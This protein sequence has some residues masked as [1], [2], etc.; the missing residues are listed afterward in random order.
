[1]ETGSGGGEQND[2]SGGVSQVAHAEGAVNGG[3]GGGW[4]P[5]STNCS[6]TTGFDEWPRAFCRPAQDFDSPPPA[7]SAAGAVERTVTAAV[8]MT[9]SRTCTKNWVLF[10]GTPFGEVR[11]SRGASS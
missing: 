9:A 7:A 2:C 6:R 1:M 11:I 4:Q 3:G 10:T 5:W 8:T